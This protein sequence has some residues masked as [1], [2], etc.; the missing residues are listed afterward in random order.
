M[1]SFLKIIL[2]IFGGIIAF[3]GFALFF[4]SNV[5]LGN[6]LS[7]LL[8]GIIIFVTLMFK[9]ISKWLKSI[10]IVCIS[11][12]I[13]CSSFLIIYGKSDNATYN[14]DAIIVLG[15]AVHGKTPSLTLKRRLDTA[16]KYLKQN[17]NPNVI[18]VVSGGQGAQEDIPEADAMENYLIKNCSIPQEKILKENA[19]TSTYEN[20][21]FSNQI[22]T[23]KL[24]KDYTAVF[25]TN[26][27][28]ILRANLCAKRAGIKNI[29]HLHSNTTLSY[30]ISGALRECLAVVKY[31]IFKN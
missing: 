6:F 2:A 26:E 27:Y 4:V 14:E 20:F 11:V 23:E 3:N 16:T 10:L 19:S 21:K 25:I 29:N 9:N 12:A 24:G 28:H 8:G 7:V 22:L 30:L 1:K 31:A 13:V 5:N 18:I 17:S 15:A